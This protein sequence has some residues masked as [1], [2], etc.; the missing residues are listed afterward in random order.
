MLTRLDLG[1][2]TGDLAGRLP[3]PDPGGEGPVAAVQAIV[4][5]VR[6][7]GDAAVIELT[8]RFDGVTLAA[9]RVPVDE[10]ADGAGERPD[11]VGRGPHRGS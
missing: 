4:A 11:R 8:E 6:D 10:V 1:A 7:R 2:A 9:L 3:R 5:D